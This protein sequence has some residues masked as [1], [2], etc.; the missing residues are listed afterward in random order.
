M[1]EGLLTEW[2]WRRQSVR[3]R[4]TGA[5]CWGAQCM[6]G[7]QRRALKQNRAFHALLLILSLAAALLL[8]VIASIPRE[9]PRYGEI[10]AQTEQTAEKP[11]V[12]ELSAVRYALPEGLAYTARTYHREELL[13]GR[14]MLIDEAHPL[15]Q[16]VPAPNTMSIAAYGKGMVPVSDLTVKS[17][18]ETIMALTRLFADLRGR[19]AGGF[20]VC[21]ATMTRWEQ[22]EWQ[23]STFRA[24]AAGMP[25][26]SALAKALAECDA[27]GTGELQQEYTVDLRWMDSAGGQADAHALERTPRGRTLLQTAWRYG[28]I[29]VP[30]EG[31]STRGYRFRYVGEAHATAMTYLDVELDEYLRLLHEKRVLTVKRDDSVSYLILCQP[32]QGA[33]VEFRLPQGAAC[34]AGLDNTG[35][36]VAACTIAG[37]E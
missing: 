26:E 20:A 27:P 18:K 9:K 10:S 3:A 34:E 28:F 36:A 13:R 12:R 21:R 5:R 30:R 23:L 15:P 32:M 33:Y 11:R 4:K 24:C 7:K 8:P 31:E 22:R 25:L 6:L 14:L 37:G 35:Y 2:E 29:R 17:G 16:G 1:A 19:G